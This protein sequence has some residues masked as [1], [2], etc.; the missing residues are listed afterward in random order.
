MQSGL[1]NTVLLLSQVHVYQIYGKISH[2]K[3]SDKLTYANSADP[4]HIAT[5]QGLHCLLFHHVF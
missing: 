1:C 3:V 4:D 2:T 5:D